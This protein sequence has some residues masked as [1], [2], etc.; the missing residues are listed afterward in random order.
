MRGMTTIFGV[1]I[2]DST[3]HVL[4][5]VGL[6]LVAL[7]DH[8]LTGTGKIR[9]NSLVSLVAAV[10]RAL[11]FAKV[12]VVGRVVSSA[13]DRGVS[14][15]SDKPI[16]P[17]DAEGKPA[18]QRCEEP[19]CFITMSY[20]SPKFCPE[21]NYL[22]TDGS[23][24]KPEEPQNR[25]L[26][27]GKQPKGI[28]AILLLVILLFPTLPACAGT[29]AQRF[30]RAVLGA[31]KTVTAARRGLVVYGKTYTEAVVREYG[32]KNPAEGRKKLDEWQVLSSQA[33][34]GIDAAD[35]VV[36]EGYVVA[37]ALAA[38]VATQPQREAWVRLAAQSLGKL[39][40]LLDAVRRVV[41]PSS[42]GAVTGGAK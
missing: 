9:A 26:R 15:P 1:P 5:T 20:G 32:G 35:A 40:E 14:A 2:D 11:G 29:Q 3:L 7:L 19:S 4:L 34:S 33:A 28:G 31:A 37:Q 8:W 24:Q 16:V 6:A 10:L 27:E 21:H 39:R 13:A 38:G 36:E 41:Y 25:R 12:P 18:A 17:A 30:E 22:N 23:L 42:A